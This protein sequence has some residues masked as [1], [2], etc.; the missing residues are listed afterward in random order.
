MEVKP[1]LM[2]PLNHNTLQLF[3]V[4]KTLRPFLSP[5]FRNFLSMLFVPISLHGS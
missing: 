3:E 5:F 1:L 4:K 2:G